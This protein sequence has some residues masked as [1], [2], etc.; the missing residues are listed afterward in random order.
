MIDY[1]I[2]TNGGGGFFAIML[3]KK[4]DIALTFINKK[5]DL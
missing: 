3:I 4:F 1:Q 5:G 2:I